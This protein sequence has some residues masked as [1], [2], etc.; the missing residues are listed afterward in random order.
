MEKCDMLEDAFRCC[1][2]TCRGIVKIGE[3]QCRVPAE[4]LTETE[5]K[6]DTPYY[7]ECSQCHRLHSHNGR[8]AM[9]KSGKRAFLQ[10]G[11]NVV[12]W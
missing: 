12:Y 10:S 3:K 5:K 9:S 2:E 4:E 7:Y 8:E 11:Y 1:E 6:P